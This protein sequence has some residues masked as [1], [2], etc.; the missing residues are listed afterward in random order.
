MKQDPWKDGQTEAHGLTE[1]LSIRMGKVTFRARGQE[2]HFIFGP[3]L[4]AL[5]INQ[6][7]HGT[8]VVHR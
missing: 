8:P 7:D 4:Y 3:I 5:A 1:I 6:M 2:K